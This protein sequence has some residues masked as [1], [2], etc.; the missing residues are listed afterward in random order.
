MSCNLLLHHPLLY[1]LSAEE[2]HGHRRTDGGYRPCDGGYWPTDGICWP[3][4]GVYGF[5]LVNHQPL[6]ALERPGTIHQQC[7]RLCRQAKVIKSWMNR[8]VIAAK[9]A[10]GN[11]LR[12][13][14]KKAC[15]RSIDDCCQL[16]SNRRQFIVVVCQPV[17]PF[18]P[19]AHSVRP[20]VPSVRRFRPSVRPP[21]VRHPSAVRPPSVG[22]CVCANHPGPPATIKCSTGLS[23]RSRKTPSRER[24]LM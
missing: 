19:S 21:S 1:F 8:K 13:N 9:H 11:P 18:R 23:E 7:T 6:E 4:D 14:L 20:P 12:L 10:C 22:C 17:S 15:Y 5:L 3:T 16:K 2:R 24:F